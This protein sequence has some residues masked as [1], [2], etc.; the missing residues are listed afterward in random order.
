MTAKDK[1]IE[2]VNKMIAITLS[3]KK[4]NATTCVD[5]V[6]KQFEG[7]HKPEYCAFDAIGER[8]FTFESEHEECMTGYD[9][10]AYWEQVKEE[11][12]LIS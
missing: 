7:L 6:L 10:V 12:Q 3:G 2:L 9:M 5:E 11:I 1:A 8:K 4:R